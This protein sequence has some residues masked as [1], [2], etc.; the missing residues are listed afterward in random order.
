MVMQD[1]MTSLNPLQT[2]GRQIEE[3]VVLHQGLKG[4]AAKKA[5]LEIL[6]DVGIDEPPSGTS[7]TRTNFRAGCGS[8]WLSRLRWPAGRRF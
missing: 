4:E 3:A 8:G 7:S 6:A 5:V 2:I 1:P